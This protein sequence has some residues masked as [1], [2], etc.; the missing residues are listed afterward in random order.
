MTGVLVFTLATG[1][2]VGITKNHLLNLYPTW[3]SETVVKEQK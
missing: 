3:S 1:S 2:F